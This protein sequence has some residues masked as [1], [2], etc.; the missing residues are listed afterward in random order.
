LGQSG[1]Y[2]WSWRT[3]KMFVSVGIT[4]GLWYPMER[5]IDTMDWKAS[6]ALHNNDE[7][8]WWRSIIIVKIRVAFHVLCYTQVKGK[9]VAGVASEAG[10][11]SETPPP[12]SSLH[13]GN[14]RRQAFQNSYQRSRPRSWAAKVKWSHRFPQ[15]H[16]EIVIIR[17]IASS[18]F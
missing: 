7:T 6:T 3:W 1:I 9:Q 13:L 14:D 2:H 4:V 11:T 5:W 10:K 17:D 16:L 8:R 15:F 12:S 18:K